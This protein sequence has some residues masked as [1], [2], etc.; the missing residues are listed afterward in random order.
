MFKYKGAI[1]VIGVLALGALLVSVSGKTVAAPASGAWHV[2]AQH[3]TVQLITDGTTDFG[4]KK[5]TYTLGF[6]RVNGDFKLDDANLDSS[7]L[8]LHIYPANSTAPVIGEDGKYKTEWLANQ[9]NHTLMC[10][11]SKKITR[12]PDGKL[13][14]TGDLVLTRVDRNVELEPNEAYSGPVYGPPVVHR[15][16]RE[17]TF[18]LDLAPAAQGGKQAAGVEATGSTS[19][20]RET[21]PE[22]VKAAIATYWPPVVMDEKC[23][24]TSGGTEDYRGSSCTGTFMD[25]PGLPVEST[26][27]GEDYGGPSNFD[28]V[29]GNQL[30]ILLRLRLANKAASQTANGM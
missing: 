25:A 8:D 23:Q 26:R 28:A 11:H 27:I 4:K 3:S 6:A 16:V 9:A 22:L 14:V 19:M 17:A 13:Q 5:I 24:N 1:A 2:D 12:G 18:V 15:V 30:T 21:Y 20:S 7:K 29:A 10:F